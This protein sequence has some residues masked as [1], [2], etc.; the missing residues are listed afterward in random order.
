MF[1]FER[2]EKYLFRLSSFSSNTNVSFYS[3]IF[4]EVNFFVRKRIILF[5]SVF[6]LIAIGGHFFKKQ[7]YFCWA[8]FPL[9]AT[10][11]WRPNRLERLQKSLLATLSTQ[12]SQKETKMGEN[13]FLQIY[14]W[15]CN[16]LKS[17][18]WVEGR[19]ES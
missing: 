17:Y 9:I 12:L 5:S 10:F 18:K 7:I 3:D 2:K 16:A 15:R 8:V 6:P 13:I 14:R 4:R 19:T 1:F 11:F